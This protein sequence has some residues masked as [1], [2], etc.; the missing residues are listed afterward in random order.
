MEPDPEL[1]EIKASGAVVHRTGTRGV[2]LALV[3]R[4][5]YDEW[6]L[7]KG[8]LDPGEDWAAAARREVEEETGQRGRLG[9][10]LDPVFYDDRKGRR[11][12]V[13]YWLLAADPDGGAPFEA[14]AEVDEVR[15]LAP[16]AALERLTYA[17]DRAVLQQ[18][19]PELG[20]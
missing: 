16:Q 17:K 19:V 12:A 14:N 4:P 3:H 11:K 5:K 13:R 7:P 8:K 1:A 9:R 20:A 18:A 15:W 10:E 6:S 2:E